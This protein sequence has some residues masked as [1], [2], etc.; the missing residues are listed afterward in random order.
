[1]VHVFHGWMKV[2]GRGAKI[3]L[4]NVIKKWSLMFKQHL[5]N[6]VTSRWGCGHM[7]QTSHC[8]ALELL[9]MLR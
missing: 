2:D 7:A 6:H 8:S 4:V 5:I 1:M 3:S 9:L